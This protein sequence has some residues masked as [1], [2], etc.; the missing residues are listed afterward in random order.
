MGETTSSGSVLEELRQ[1]TIE[2]YAAGDAERATGLYVD[3][4]VQ[5]PP[6]RPA[7]AGRES[8]R[9]SYQMVFGHGGLTLRMEPWETVVAGREARERGAY[10]LASGDQTLLTGKYMVVAAKQDD[11]DWRYVWSTVTP[12]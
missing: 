11:G 6:G 9:R 7:A 12:D 5:Q 2:A 1:R 3:D 10:H 8:I 4:G